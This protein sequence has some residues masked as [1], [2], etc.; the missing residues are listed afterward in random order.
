MATNSRFSA[1]QQLCPDIV[2]LYVLDG[3]RLDV[4]KKEMESRMSGLNLT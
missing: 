4:V 3:H 2:R 1:F